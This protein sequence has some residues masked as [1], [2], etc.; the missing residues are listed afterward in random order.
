MPLFSATFIGYM[1]NYFMPARMGEL[2]RPLIISKKEGVKVTSM[3]ATVALE[4]TVDL[5]GLIIFT[6]VTLILLPAPHDNRQTDISVIQTMDSVSQLDSGT[7]TDNN[8]FLFWEV[9]E[10]QH[11]YSFIQWQFM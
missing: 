7:D 11:G 1:A 9:K 5:L 4:R 2:I 10:K 6:I 3:L 8:K